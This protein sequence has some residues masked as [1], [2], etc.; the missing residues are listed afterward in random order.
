[1]EEGSV[2]NYLAK[3][4][5]SQIPVELRLKWARQ[6]AKAVAFIHSKGVI[7]CDIHTNNLLLDGELDIKLCDF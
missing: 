1:V 5:I 6:A 2:K 4:P 7:Y 3:K